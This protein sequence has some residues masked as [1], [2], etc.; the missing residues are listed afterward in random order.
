MVIRR[1]TV[2]I[3]GY[4]TAVALVTA[5][6]P[7]GLLCG[8]VGAAV[9]L[10]DLT[11]SAWACL[12]LLAVAAL[13]A[14]GVVAAAQRAVDALTRRAVLA[15]LILARVIALTGGPSL[16]DDDHRY[17][18]EGRAQRLGLAVP[19]ATPPA[20]IV[21]PPD[22]GT[23]ARVNHPDV[24]AAYPPGSELA[25]LALVGLG[26]ATGHP[27][28]PLRLALALADA[29]VL[30]LLYRRRGA[31]FAWYGAH[32]LPIAEVALA[33]HLDG[34]GALLLLLAALAARRP[35]LAGALLGAAAHVKPIALVGLVGVPRGRAA[36]AALAVGAVLA[37][38]HLLAG[39]PILSGLTQY[40]TRWR[41]SPFGFA[42]LEAPF[43]PFFAERAAR[44]VYTHLE[45]GG[46]R[47]L[48]DHGFVARAIASVLLIALLVWVARRRA[49]PEAR[50]AAALAVAWFLA[51]TIHPWYLVWLVPFAALLRSRA[52][53]GAAAAAPLLYQPV[54]AF[55]AGGEWSE[56]VWPRLLVLA[57]A[58]LG[59]V[60]DVRGGARPPP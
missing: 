2:I 15:G 39:A 7:V 47:V 20:R 6:L 1:C 56:A 4:S 43:K 19:Y 34:F 46:L 44:G 9:A 42:L 11:G 53:W 58:G 60:L 32:P 27:R 49:R 48:V 33:G 13:A 38:P 59:A 28:A 30:L 16:S 40:A 10:G 29:L 54:F 23:T 37:V 5:M 52:L 14:I 21:P 17:V 8:A 26:D 50:I 36:L 18:H 3:G 24:P 41:G 25:L 57:G 31:S 55:H 35:A 51:P 22:D 45:V 12:A